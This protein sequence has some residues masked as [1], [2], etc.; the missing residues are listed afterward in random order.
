[1]GHL[2]VI[3]G[4]EC[5]RALERAGFVFD[6]QVGSHMVMERGAVSVPVPNH[7]ELKKGTLANII[8]RAGMTV[9]EFTSLL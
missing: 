3:S 8:R 9:E 5:R 7:R 6:R 1:M 2:P 4:R